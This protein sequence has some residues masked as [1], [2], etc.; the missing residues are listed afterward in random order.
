MH[1]N[2][3]SMDIFY[4]R[5]EKKSWNK[6]LLRIKHLE[7]LSFAVNN[8]G[9]FLTDGLVTFCQ[10]EVMKLH[11]ASKWMWLHTLRNKGSQL[12]PLSGDVFF[13]WS[14]ETVKKLL[15]RSNNNYPLKHMKTVG[16][17][18]VEEPLV[19]SQRCCCPGRPEQEVLRHY[20]SNTLWVHRGK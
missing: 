2:T 9:L 4:I 8:V 12:T 19:S 17:V 20:R 6:I 10:T 7:I 15:L 1:C 18:S 13:F 11:E 16:E 14:S 5:V 3:T